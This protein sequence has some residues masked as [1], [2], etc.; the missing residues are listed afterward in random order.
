MPPRPQP[1]FDLKPIKGRPRG[2][3]IARRGQ[4]PVVIQVDLPRPQEQEEL[5]PPEDEGRVQPLSQRHGTDAEAQTPFLIGEK[6]THFA[7]GP[8]SPYSTSLPNCIAYAG[9]GAI[10]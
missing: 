7:A 8:S 2:L 10:F 9:F 5:H 3:N 4:R 1:P 6:K